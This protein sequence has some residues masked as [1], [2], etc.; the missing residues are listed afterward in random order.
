MRR[1]SREIVDGD[2]R[3]IARD[4]ARPPIDDRTTELAELRE[5]LAF[6][7]AEMEKKAAPDAP[8]SALADAMIRKFKAEQGL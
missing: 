7:T 1:N 6:D 5:R 4:E 2:R 3:D 8:Y